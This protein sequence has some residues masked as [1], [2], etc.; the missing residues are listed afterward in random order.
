MKTCVARVTVLERHADGSNRQ[1]VITR[2]VGPATTVKELFDWWEKRVH[3]PLNGEFATREIV[4]SPDDAEP[5][6]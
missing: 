4:L 2:T 6:Y 1:F 5:Q 3:D